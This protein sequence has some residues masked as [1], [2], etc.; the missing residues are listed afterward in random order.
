TDRLVGARIRLCACVEIRSV[1]PR[2]P[3]FPLTRPKFFGRSYQVPTGPDCRQRRGV[4][5]VP[6]RR[7]RLADVLAVNNEVA[8]L[9][10]P[11][12]SDAAE[13]ATARGHGQNLLRHHPSSS[14]MISRYARSF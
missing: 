2:E 1:M 10:R 6:M 14:A 9:T 7:P 12:G 8:V 3:P 11:A 5:V 13:L 4:R